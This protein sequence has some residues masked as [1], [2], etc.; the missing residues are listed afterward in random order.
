MTERMKAFLQKV[1]ADEALA[2]QVGAL[3]RDGLIALSEQ[4]G[5]GL[6]AADFAE[7]SDE[8]DDEELPDFFKELMRE[9]RADK[10]EPQEPYPP[11]RDEPPKDSAQENNPEKNNDMNIILMFRIYYEMGFL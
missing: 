3:D 4:L 8:L 11:K 1:S 5:V 9:M 6:T 7:A 2:A 10:D